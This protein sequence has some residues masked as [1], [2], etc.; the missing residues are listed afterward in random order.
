MQN[1]TRAAGF[2]DHIKILF[3]HGALKAHGGSMNVFAC[4]CL[5]SS[6]SVSTPLSWAKAVKRSN[7]APKRSKARCWGTDWLQS[8]LCSWQAP[9]HFFMRFLMLFFCPRVLPFPKTPIS[10]SCNWIQKLHPAAPCKNIVKLNK[11]QSGTRRFW[12][13]LLI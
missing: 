2:T 7:L 12:A 9:V 5:S 10:V 11:H 1:V 4:S 8:A 3:W 6:I 13:R